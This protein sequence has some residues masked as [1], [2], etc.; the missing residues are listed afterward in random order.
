MRLSLY[1]TL[2]RKVEDFV[3]L[4]K[5]NVR[6]YVCGPTVYDYDHIGHARTFLAFDLLHR[7]LKYVLK[8]KVT[9]VQNITDVGHLVNDA[10]VG[11][12]KI[13]KKAAEVGQSAKEIVQHYSD[14][15]FRDMDALNIESP[16]HSPSASGHIK[17]IIDFVS[18]LVGSGYAYVTNQG[19]VYFSVARDPGYGKLSNRSL[20]E[21]LTGTRVETANDKR[22]EADFAL[23]KAANVGMSEEYLWPSP[24]GKGFP[25][26]HI[27]CSAMSRK[28][29]GD[30]FDI[31]GS[32]VEHI[33][34]HHENEIAQSESLTGKEMA[35]FW[36]HSGMLTINGSKMSK[37][38]HNTVTISEALK[39]YSSNELRFAFFHTHYRKPLDY[40][41]PV[42]EQGV[43]FRKALF[44][45]Y[46]HMLKADNTSNKYQSIVEALLTDLDTPKAL[47]LWKDCMSD[48]TID[49]TESLMQI[50]GIKYLPIEHNDKAMR[51]ATERNKARD[52][53]DYLTADNRKNEIIQLGYEAIDTPEGSKYIPR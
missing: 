29:L 7:V 6:M 21:L 47:A 38:L 11:P 5:E 13:Q 32:A 35:R 10:E 31:H 24:W 2:S 42:M 15:H 39:E 50:F 40:T 41:K 45:V 52:E 14:A 19:N 23:W 49:E 18:E 25:G 12:D 3:P 28:Y 53:Q 22:S 8:Y 33:F 37:S 43:A 16:T 1:N 36:V 51:L 17:E 4:D 27:E 44:N 20:T 9:Y 48:L 26:W 46:P 34:P 30:T